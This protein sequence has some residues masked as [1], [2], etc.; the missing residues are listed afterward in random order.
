MPKALLWSNPELNTTRIY[1]LVYYYGKE[2]N[3]SQHICYRITNPKEQRYVLV[4]RKVQTYLKDCIILMPKVL[5]TKENTSNFYY[6]KPA[7]VDKNKKQ[8]ESPAFIF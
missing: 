1:N 8:G 7:K 2:D 6:E 4:E 5:L 3:K